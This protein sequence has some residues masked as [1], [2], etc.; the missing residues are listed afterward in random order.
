[1]YYWVS[2][3]FTEQFELRDFPY[4]IQRLHINIRNVLPGPESEAQYTLW[5]VPTAIDPQLFFSHGPALCLGELN[6]VASVFRGSLLDE[7]E[8]FMPPLSHQEDQTGLRQEPFIKNSRPK[9]HV[10]LTV[11][12]RRKPWF[13]ESNVTIVLFILTSMSLITFRVD[14][15]EVADMSSI[16]LTLILTAVAYKFIISD[17]MPKCSYFTILDKYI[18]ACFAMLSA[19]VLENA[20]AQELRPYLFIAVSACWGMFNIVFVGR[21]LMFSAATSKVLA[22]M[23]LE[24]FVGKRADA[25]MVEWSIL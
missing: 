6:T 18:L 20:F 2:G 8:L 3:T 11:V 22:T 15:S 9:H 23:R 13:F 19:M 12:V 21:C 10:L 24:P 16:T 4:D 7:F 14:A 1:M 17:N 5:P 25:K